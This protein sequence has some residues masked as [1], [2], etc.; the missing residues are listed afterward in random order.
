MSDQNWTQEPWPLHGSPAEPG[1]D[2]DYVRLNRDDYERARDCVDACKGMKDPERELPMLV[3]IAEKLKKAVIAQDAM[4]N[5]LVG[6]I[7]P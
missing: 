1:K 2:E 3:S 4:T 5:W 6:R 7:E